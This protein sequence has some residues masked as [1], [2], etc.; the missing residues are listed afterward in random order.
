MRIGITGH[1]RLD[2][3]ATWSWVEQ[4]IERQLNSAGRPLVGL[5]SLAIGTDQLFARLV[6]G[7]GGRV[8]AVIPFADYER[9]FD[10]ESRKMYRYLLNLASVEV[11]NVDGTEE[12][13]FLAAGKRVVDLSE[14]M[15]VVWDGRPP[16][17][18]GGTAD[19]VHYAVKNGVA[20]IHLNPISLIVSEVSL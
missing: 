8:H 15:I 17:G 14:V 16:K 18:K 2:S 9:T 12:D 4:A 1:Q 19:I 10:L 20:T 11:L 6:L 13:A 3:P 7:Q 5:T